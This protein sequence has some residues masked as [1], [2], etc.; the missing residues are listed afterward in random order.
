MDV[1][2]S[3]SDVLQSAINLKIVTVVGDVSVE[4]TD[5]RVKLTVLGGEPKGLQ[6]EMNLLLGDITTKMS[7]AF[8]DGQLPDVA[9]LHAEMTDKAEGIIERNVKLLLEVLEQGLAQLPDTD[10][11][12]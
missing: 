11:N 6:T 8:A 9:A 1:K 5:G 2:R 7:P 10:R 3:L 4:E 12:G